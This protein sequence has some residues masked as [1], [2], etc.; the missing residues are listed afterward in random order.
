[1]DTSQMDQILV[2]Q[3]LMNFK[4]ASEE[5]GISQPTLTYQVK[6]VEE[7]IGFAIFERNGK[8]ISM[9]PAGEQFCISIREIREDIKRAVE[10]GQNIDGRFRTSIR[11]GLPFR[12]AID[13]LPEAIRAFYE[14]TSDISI[15]P[16]F[17]AYGDVSSFMS[18]ENDIEFLLLEEAEG[19]KG[20]EIIPLYH[21]GISLIVREDD[22]LAEKDVIRIGDLDWR[23]LMIGGGSP[24][25]LKR[26]QHRVIAS[27]RVNYFNSPDHDTTLTN[28]EAG[29]G[30]CLAPDFL[31][32]KG[33]GF[34][35]IP[36]ECDEGF[37]CVLIVREGC[38]QEVTM[39]A[40]M[41]SDMYAGQR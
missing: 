32:S 26:V 31:H 33:D 36:F 25:A 12:S 34:T 24:P 27:G 30:V 28:V 10:R 4:R 9:T 23:T 40:K 29:S 11:I 6:K 19:I 22:P 18:G 21:S 7:E 20:A 2:L 38:P 14:S 13:R 3:R 41:L 15:V 35:W 39:F 17:H 37:D 5:L 16:D 1:M 8:S